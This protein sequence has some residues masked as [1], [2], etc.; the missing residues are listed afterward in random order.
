VLDPTSRSR[1]ASAWVRDAVVLVGVCR[2]HVVL[3]AG[4]ELAQCFV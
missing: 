2:T 3:L 1:V 4:G